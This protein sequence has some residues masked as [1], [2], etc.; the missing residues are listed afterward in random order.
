MLSFKGAGFRT[1]TKRL[2]PIPLCRP[3]AL[4]VRSPLHP[5]IPMVHHHLGVTMVATRRHML[6]A[7]PRIKSMIGPFDF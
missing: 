3:L 6:T 1:P 4:T 2:F 7:N 5:A